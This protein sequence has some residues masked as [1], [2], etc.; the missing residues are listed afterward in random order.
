VAEPGGATAAIPAPP[1]IPGS[2]PLAAP[3]AGTTIDTLLTPNPGDKD[4]KYAHFGTLAVERSHLPEFE[5]AQRYL[6]KDP[7][8]VAALSALETAKDAHK[9]EFITDGN[10]R[11]NHT[12]NTLYWDPKSAM[13]NTNGSTQS[14]ALGLL[15][16]EDHL[17]E[18]QQN[19][20]EISPEFAIRRRPRLPIVKNSASSKASRIARR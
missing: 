3:P 5:Q 7:E 9:I 4:P 18:H 10:D 20:K 2:G 8:A 19:P 6:A 14:A 12:T 17:I 16:E 11:Y 1:T 13:T 15:H